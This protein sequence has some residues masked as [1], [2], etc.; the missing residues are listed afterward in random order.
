MDDLLAK[1][2][3]PWP[4]PTQAEMPVDGLE[5]S[6]SVG[7]WLSGMAYPPLDARAKELTRGE[8]P[9]H[10]VPFYEDDRYLQIASIP[11]KSGKS[12]YENDR[13]PACGCDPVPRGLAYCPRCVHHAE[14]AVL[15][16]RSSSSHSGLPLE[17][18]TDQPDRPA[19]TV[20]TNTSHLGSDFRS[21]I[22]KPSVAPSNAPT[23]SRCPELRLVGA[24]NAGRNYLIRNVIGEAFPTYFTLSSWRDAQPPAERKQH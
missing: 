5:R 1:G 12:A 14:P 16:R 23:S 18:P 7:E 19:P 8:H 17:L 3:L 21:S 4:R 24:L 11:A 6:V 9:L 2:L 22:G 15:H 13:C 10:R 20:T